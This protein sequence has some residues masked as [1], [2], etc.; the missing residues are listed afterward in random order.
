MSMNN[1]FDY[2]LHNMYVSVI[3]CNDEGSFK[4]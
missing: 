3:L 1:I 2:G 4:H